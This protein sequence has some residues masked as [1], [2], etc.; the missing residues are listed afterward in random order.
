[1]EKA[2]ARARAEMRSCDAARA[3]WFAE[4]GPGPAPT[5][6]ELREAVAIREMARDEDPLRGEAVQAA[7]LIQ[8]YLGWPMFEGVVLRADGTPGRLHAWNLVPGGG[9]LDAAAD[10]HGARGPIMAMP[11][12]AA[13]GRYRREWTADYNPDLARRFPELAGC[14][15]DG[16]TDM[17]ALSSAP[18]AEAPS[19]RF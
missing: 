11:G 15:W 1:M 18:E 2:D 3:A 17:Q 7:H 10:L 6:A 13:M 5:M 12:S 19:P 16:R 14:L 9:V 4:A 8:C